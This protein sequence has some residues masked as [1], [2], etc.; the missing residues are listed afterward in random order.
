M[1]EMSK[2]SCVKSA[3]IVR[4]SS[5]GGWR[6][7]IVGTEHREINRKSRNAMGI[8]GMRALSHMSVEKYGMGA[9]VAA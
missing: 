8:R 7:R 3:C 6:Q 4:I 9:E 1:C 2:C 5:L